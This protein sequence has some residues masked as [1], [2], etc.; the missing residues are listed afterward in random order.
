LTA[1]DD[2]RDQPEGSP[3][4][5]F[6]RISSGRGRLR[7]WIWTEQ[8]IRYIRAGVSGKEM[9]HPRDERRQCC[10]EFGEASCYQRIASAVNCVRDSRESPANGVLLRR[11]YYTTLFSIYLNSASLSYL[12]GEKSAMRVPECLGIGG[13]WYFSPQRGTIEPEKDTKSSR[14][15]ADKALAFV[16]GRAKQAVS[17]RRDK[18]RD[19]SFESCKLPLERSSLT[20]K[21]RTY[22]VSNPTM[23]NTGGDTNIVGV[24]TT[25]RVALAQKK[26]EK[27]G[28]PLCL[29]QTV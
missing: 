25:L 14:T 3:K 16:F 26:E 19:A 22:A 2:P 11:T 27:K 12:F 15:A 28:P 8:F 5:S 23:R 20:T 13:A 9:V 6:R 21:L 4:G 24:K 18:T 29:G 17:N 1:R 10:G 7:F